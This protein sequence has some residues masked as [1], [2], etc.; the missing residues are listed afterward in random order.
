MDEAE[1]LARNLFYILVAAAVVYCSACI[2][3]VS[4]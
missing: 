3:M 1:K 2:V 4:I